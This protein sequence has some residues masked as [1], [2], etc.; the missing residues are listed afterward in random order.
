MRQAENLYSVQIL[1][2]E[3]PQPSKSGRWDFSRNPTTP[4][5]STRGKPGRGLRRRGRD[6]DRHGKSCLDWT[7]WLVGR[8]A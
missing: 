8:R 7:G 1:A 2:A 5:H 4:L 3:P 6:W